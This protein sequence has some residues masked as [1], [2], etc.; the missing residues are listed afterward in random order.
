[1]PKALNKTY[2]VG[3]TEKFWVTVDDIDPGQT[4][5]FEITAQL[6]A[7]GNKAAIWAD[8]NEISVNNNN[9]DLAIEYLSF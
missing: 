7:K 8:V 1:M 2:R 9:N 5:D 3:M 4:K 6:L